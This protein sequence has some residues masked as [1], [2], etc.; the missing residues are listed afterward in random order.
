MIQ[1]KERTTE[2]WIAFYEKQL[3]RLNKAP[4]N[5]D[6]NFVGDEIIAVT[7]RIEELKQLQIT[8]L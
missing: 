7:K 5:I 3:E 2:E 4:E 1:A 6:R 8:N